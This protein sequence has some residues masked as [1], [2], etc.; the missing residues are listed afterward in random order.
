MQAPGRCRCAGASRGCWC[1]GEAQPRAAGC[2]AVRRAVRRT[3]EGLQAA[4]TAAAGAVNGAAGGRRGKT[5]APLPPAW[6]RPCACRRGFHPFDRAI[7]GLWAGRG[8]RRAR[9]GACSGAP[10]SLRRRC[11]QPSI[12]ERPARPTWLAAAAAAG[13]SAG[14]GRALAGEAAQPPCSP[15]PRCRAAAPSRRRAAGQP[16]RHACKR[17][18]GEDWAGRRRPPRVVQIDRAIMRMAMQGERRVKLHEA[19]PWAAGSADMPPGWRTSRS[20]APIVC[21]ANAS[22]LQAQCCTGWCVRLRQ[23]L[24]TA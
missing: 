7:Q 22:V 8:A 18:A 4:G 20:A 13:A 14:A 16:G 2:P 24:L 17:R 23:V 9:R 15:D 11:R 21:Q 10:L 1:R 19:G 12:T 5:L 6:A 3:G